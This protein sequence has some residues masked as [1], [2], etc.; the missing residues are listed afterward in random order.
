[1]LGADAECGISGWNP[2]TP[3][4]QN[5]VVEL[6]AN[7]F[8]RETQSDLDP[9]LLLLTRGGVVD[10][11]AQGR[12]CRKLVSDLV[13]EFGQIHRLAT[14]NISGDECLFARSL[15]GRISHIAVVN[16][17]GIQRSDFKSADPG[18]VQKQMGQDDV[19]VR[20]KPGRRN[21][22]LFEGG[23][24]QVRSSNAPWSLFEFRW[25]RSSLPGAH[26]APRG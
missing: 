19:F 12:T 4:V 16:D 17:R 1:M 25:H 22:M 6:L 26:R 3:W 11:Q 5:E 23:D 15:A 9:T 24:D 2:P 21:R 18:V 7:L 13:V 20:Y 14:R 8:A 10:L